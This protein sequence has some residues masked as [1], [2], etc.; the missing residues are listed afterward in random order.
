[1]EDSRKG[2]RSRK[3]GLPPPDPHVDGGNGKK[4]HSILIRKKRKRKEDG[5]KTDWKR[6]RERKREQKGL[7]KYNSKK[8]EYSTLRLII[9]ACL[10]ILSEYVCR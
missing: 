2:G 6:K 10:R 4:S 8:G 5:R 7:K 1:M 9:R 3:K